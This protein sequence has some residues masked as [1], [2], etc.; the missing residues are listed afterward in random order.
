MAVKHLG[1]HQPADVVGGVTGPAPDGALQSG[2][3]EGLRLSAG[4]NPRMQINGTSKLFE[5]SHYR[6]IIIYCSTPG[7]TIILIL[8]LCIISILIY[9]LCSSFYSLIS[10]ILYI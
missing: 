4:P 9:L 5:V 8:S 10:Y 7:E 1:K 2:T 6:S 3:V